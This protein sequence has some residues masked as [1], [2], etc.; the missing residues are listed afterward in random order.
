M[1][2]PELNGKQIFHCW[3]FAHFLLLYARTLHV[4][5]CLWLRV[6]MTIWGMTMDSTVWCAHVIYLVSDVPRVVT[7]CCLQNWR[8]F[9]ITIA[10]SSRL[11]MSRPTLARIGNF[12]LG[13]TIIQLVNAMMI[14]LSRGYL[15][16]SPSDINSQE[17]SWQNHP[18]IWLSQLCSALKTPINALNTEGI[19]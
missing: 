7:C 1:T 12:Q 4:T 8:Q 19:I 13:D 5:L 18:I 2:C 14:K 9:W 16:S 15:S 10:Q 3:P 17:L 6:R 11:S